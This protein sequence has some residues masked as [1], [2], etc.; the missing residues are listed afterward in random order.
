MQEFSVQFCAPTDLCVSLFALLSGYFYA[1]SAGTLS[2]SLRKITD[3]LISYWLLC[4]P[5][6]AVAALTGCN[7]LSKTGLVLEMLGLESIVMSFCWYVY[8]F[9]IVMLAIPLL[10]RKDSRSPVMDALVLLNGLLLCYIAAALTEPVRKAVI[11]CKERL[12]AWIAG[13][14]PQREALK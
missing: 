7:T 8:F 6:V 11:G 3:F 9:C 12:F 2:Y 5:M 10:A 4:I 1:F 13:I 14:L